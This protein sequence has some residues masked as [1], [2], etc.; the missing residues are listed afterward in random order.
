MMSIEPV[1]TGWGNGPHSDWANGLDQPKE[2]LMKTLSENLKELSDHIVSTA[3]EI[4]TAEQQSREKL[5]ASIKKSRVEAKARQDQFAA[6]VKAKQSAAALQW[7]EL[8]ANYNQ[9]VMQI[10][11]KIATSKEAREAKKAAKRADDA[12]AYAEAAILF[13]F[14]AIDEAEVAVLEAIAARADAESVD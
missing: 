14:L 6:N 9:K 5:E 4:E 11:N 2:K 7:E 1:T 12:E 10:K 13:V 8:Q 3:K